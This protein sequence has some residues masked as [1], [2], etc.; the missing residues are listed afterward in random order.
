MDFWYKG[1]RRYEKPPKKSRRNKAQQPKEIH[2]SSGNI[3]EL[4]SP[5]TWW[6]LKVFNILDVAKE[7]V[8]E[9]YLAVFLA[10]WLC[11]FVIPGRIII[12]IVLGFHGGKTNGF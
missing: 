7:D 2:N 10:Y 6:N 1:T 12:S 3:T 9:T 11:Q 4:L 5:H 8:N